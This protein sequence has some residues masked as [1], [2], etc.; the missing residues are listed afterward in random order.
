MK[1]SIKL[2]AL[3][4]IMSLFVL[5]FQCHKPYKNNHT[6]QIEGEFQDS[7]GAPIPYFE[8]YI[9]HREVFYTTPIEQ[10][11][12]EKTIKTDAYGKFKILTPQLLETRDR[13]PALVF[14]DTTWKYEIELLPGE[15][16]QR[17]FVPIY[18]NGTTNSNINLGTLI[19]QQ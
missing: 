6:L 14:V 9:S 2:I 11:G 8:F 1:T 12:S 13:M 17:Y 10:R 15:F 3:L 16:G 5:S 19:I 7:N 18:T 4:L